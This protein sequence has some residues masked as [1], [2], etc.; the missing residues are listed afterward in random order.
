MSPTVPGQMVAA[1]REWR[2]APSAS[3]PSSRAQAVIE[4]ALRRVPRAR[5]AG[6]TEAAAAALPASVFPQGGQTDARRALA[7]AAQPAA[8]QPG[9]GAARP[10]RCQRERNR[11]AVASDAARRLLA[12]RWPAAR[13]AAEMKQAPPAIP[14]AATCAGQRRTACAASIEAMAPAFAD[15]ARGLAGRPAEAAQAAAQLEF[16]DRRD[17]RATR[18]TRRSRMAYGATCC[19]RGRNCATRSASPRTAPP[20]QVVAG[21][22][23]GGPR[24]CG[25]A[26]RPGRPRGPA[27]ARPSCRAGRAAWRGSA[28]WA[29][30]RRPAIATA[31]AQREVA[32]LDAEGRWLGGR[33]VSQ[34]AQI[35]T[36]GLGGNHGVG[37]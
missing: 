19:W 25:Q 18:A 29:R 5:Q 34:R 35:T 10:M 6:Q 8:D 9:G 23:G 16:V 30:C 36:F 14:T 3:R 32:R 26:M 24:R 7:V 11:I 37:Y 31:L 1:R 33:P 20:E 13:A 22:A 27:G 28:S 17:R 21:T 12:A 2:A 15:R 4:L